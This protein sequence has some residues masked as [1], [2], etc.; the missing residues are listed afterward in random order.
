MGAAGLVRA[1]GVQERAKR[2]QERPKSGQERLKMDQERA[3]S[4]QE[5]PKSGLR[6]AQSGQERFKSG[7]KGILDASWLVLGPFWKQKSLF[8][9]RNSNTF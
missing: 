2:R 5:R 1:K 4:G 6:A 3:K 7:P 8:F 9:L